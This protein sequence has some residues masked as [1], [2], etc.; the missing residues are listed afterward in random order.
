MPGSPPCQISSQQ[1][2]AQPKGTPCFA[3]WISRHKDD[4]LR[5]ASLA[6]LWMGKGQVVGHLE[7]EVAEDDM[8]GNHTVW[9][10]SPGKQ[11]VWEQG[12][13]RDRAKERR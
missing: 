1:S 6:R 2:K 13:A 10:M 12:E 9:P 8:E 4:V 3:S 7:E 11:R 5:W